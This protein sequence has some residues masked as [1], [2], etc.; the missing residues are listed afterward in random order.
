MAKFQIHNVEDEI[1]PEAKITSPHFNHDRYEWVTRNTY[2]SEFWLELKEY[3]YEV[4]IEFLATPMSRGAV[5]LVEGIVDRWKIGSGDLT[6]LV[7]LDSIRD[8]HKPII[9]S[10]GMSSLFELRRAY[11]FVREKTED[12]T[13]MHCVSNYPCKMEDL[14]LLTIPFLKKQF[15]KAKIGFS[16]HSLE[17]STGAMAIALGA[18]VIEK[19]FTLDRN[20]WGPDHKCSLL[21]H[22]FAQ[23]VKEIK[24]GTEEISKVAL[25]VETKFVN[26]EE[27]K[28]R[29]VFHKGLY[30]NRDVKKGELISRED[31]IALRPRGDAP[32]SQD[33]ELYID[34]VAG[35]D[36]HKYDS[37]WK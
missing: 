23:M 17:I 9:L 24:M 1:H 7:L 10:S 34:H 20:A 36:Y 6:D 21:P 14:N 3:C 12:V 22:E 30:A 16:D 5:H 27:M 4:G 8:Y 25:G 2:P 37:L 26:E 19:H 13:I 29:K 15:P 11:N 18:E 28:F 31:I 32:S 35:K 33:Y